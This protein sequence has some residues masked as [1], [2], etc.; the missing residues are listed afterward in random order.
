MLN[1]FFSP[2][3]MAVFTSNVLLILTS[4]CFINR[5]LMLNI[6][7]RVLALLIGLTILRFLFP[8][9]L[10]ISTNVNLPETI[11]IFIV[12]LR[13]PFIQINSIGI[14]IWN[15]F[16]IVWFSGIIIKCISFIRLYGKAKFTFLQGE[17][18]AY[19]EPYKSMLERICLER[20]KKNCFK[21]VR[22]PNIQTVELFGFVKPI[23]LIPTWLELTDEDL[24]I[25][26]CHETAHFFHHDLMIKYLVK[27]ITI[28]YWWNPFCHIINKQLDVILEMRIDD[29]LVASGTTSLKKYHNCLLHSAEKLI[30]YTEKTK[31]TLSFASVSDDILVQRFEMLTKHKENYYKIL[32]IFVTL[33]MLFIYCMSYVFI[34]EAYYIPPSIRETTQGIGDDN[35]Y[36]I[37]NEAGSYDVY[38]GNQYIETVTSLKE[39]P[40]DVVIKQKEEKINDKS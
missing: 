14:S 10:P 20:S 24:Y 5:K 7:Y 30:K 33:G 8:I 9:E 2:A 17:D 40:A 19:C 1:N 21:I 22:L 36:I 25:T 35:N 38:I 11:S 3:L 32:S 26:L 15:I 6:G 31:L 39:F 29:N 12:S 28:F 37:E 27:I 13:H 34:F 4:L 23:I 16:V 18:I